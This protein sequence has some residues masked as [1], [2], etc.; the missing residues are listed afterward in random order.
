[1][2]RRELLQE[3]SRM[4]VEE[5]DGVA[6]VIRGYAAM[7]Y[8]SRKAGT[9]YE[10]WEGAKER[11]LPGAFD[12]SLSDGA[13]VIA[14]FNHDPSLLL[15]R[16][17]AGTVRLSKDDRGLKYEIDPPDVSYARDLLVSLRRGDVAGSSFAFSVAEGGE[18]WSYDKKGQEIRELSDLDLVDVSPVT[19]PAYKATTAGVRSEFVAEARESRNAWAE[20]AHE[21]HHDTPEEWRKVTDEL[22]SEVTRLNAELMELHK[23]KHDH[24]LQR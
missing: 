3:F 4:E 16:T 17:S 1:M 20:D 10:L 11:I 15:G 21:A 9:E 2:E 19:S 14:A 24:L 22:R 8:N 12:R 5:R 23:H 6:P 7:F 18:R 13:D